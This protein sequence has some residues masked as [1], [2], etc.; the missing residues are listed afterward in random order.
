MEGR[1]R[2]QRHHGRRGPAAARV[3]RHPHDRGRPRRPPA[4]SARSSAPTAPG[5]RSTAARATCRPRSRRTSRCGWPA[6]RPTP[7]TCE[8]R[9]VRAGRGR[10]RAR[11][12]CSPGSGSRCSACGLG[13]A[14]GAA[15]GDHVPAARGSRSTSTTSAAGPA[16]R[17]CRSPSWQPSSRCGRCRSASTSCAPGSAA[18]HGR[19]PCSM[20][21]VLPAPRPRAAP[22]RAPPAPARCGGWPMRRAAEWIARPPGGR[23]LAGAASS[24]RGCTRCIAL[25]LLG[26][27]ARP[28]RRCAP[29]SP[30][31]TASPS[32]S[33]PPDGRSAGS[34]RASRRCGTPRWR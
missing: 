20:G 3:P 14:A 5:R 4:G 18:G 24:R 25:H 31:S 10:A 21:R 33:R 28:S 19:Q 27:P 16:R 1:A 22:L 26:L 32:A 13:R 9:R 17:S 34:R 11:P 15:A 8:R 30:A 6:I 2:D 7:R 23:R 29:A 12:G